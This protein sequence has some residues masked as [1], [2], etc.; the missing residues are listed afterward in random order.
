[1]FSSWTHRVLHPPAIGI[2]I[3]DL[4][5]KFLGLQRRRG[6]LAIRSFGE[7]AV[8]AGVITDGEIRDEAALARLL[9]EG[10]KRSGVR[11]RWCVAALPEEKS[12]VRVL[13][14]P[15]LKTEDVERA[16]RWE[17]EGVI[18]LPFED[19]YYDHE[20]I[21]DG[22]SG[23]TDVLI[24]AFPRAIIHPYHRVLTAA[25]CTPLALE[26][27]SQAISRAVVPAASSSL[28]IMDFGAVR[29]SVIVFAGGSLFFTKSIPIGGRDLESAIARGLNISAEQARAVKI[30]TGISGE[31]G[32]RMNEV[33]APLLSKLT[34]ELSQTLD[35]YREHPRRRHTELA[36]ISAILLSGGDANLSGLETY[37][38]TAI[39]RPVELADPFTRVTLG[40]GV[41]PPMPQN[42]AQQYTT[43]IGLA[44]RAIGM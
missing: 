20:V 5:V 31:G 23:H 27:E 6:R 30:E 19:I 7:F 2:D 13:E 22:Q 25:G 24:T 35:F 29:T 44:L 34:V 21:P 9:A 41:V 17:V 38:A 26:L 32:E 11:D 28:L 16:V 14:L 18:P 10:L 36:D 40:A 15:P 1:M 42:Q 12:F 43:A 3:S 39:E 4:S 33:L 37:L 8:P